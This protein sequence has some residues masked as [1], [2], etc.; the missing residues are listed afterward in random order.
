MSPVRA[1]LGFRL[2]FEG[3]PLDAMVS[4]KYA[5]ALVVGVVAGAYAVGVDDGAN[6]AAEWARALNCALAF[7]WAMC[8]KSETES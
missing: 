1:R 2:C 3:R 6:A 5:L 7:A 4:E 8:R